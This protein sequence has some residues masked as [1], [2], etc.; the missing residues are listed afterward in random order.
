MKKS[1][2]AGIGGRYGLN[3]IWMP[4]FIWARR[5]GAVFVGGEKKGAVLFTH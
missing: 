1:T 4:S 5:K 3:I 2:V